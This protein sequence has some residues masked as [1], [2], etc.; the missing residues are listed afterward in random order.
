MDSICAAAP[1]VGCMSGN[2]PRQV[3]GSASST[4]NLTTPTGAHIDTLCTNSGSLRTPYDS[5]T[6]PQLLALKFQDHPY[7][8]VRD[9]A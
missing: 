1:V 9:V 3:A 7:A 8:T 6:E 4:T 2:A 5:E